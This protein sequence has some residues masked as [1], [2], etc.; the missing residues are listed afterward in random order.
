M[1]IHLRR[2]GVALVLTSA[3][4]AVSAPLAMADG[5]AVSAQLVAGKLQ[6]TG[7]ALNDTVT[8]RL[9]T[10]GTID[11]HA[12]T[13]RAPDF[14]FRR[15]EVSTI[16][17]DLG[18]G[19]DMVAMVET[20]GSFTDTIPTTISTGDG[21][22]EITG[23]RGDETLLAGPGPDV[24]DG[25]GGRDLILLG[26]GDDRS[27]WAPGDGTDVIEGQ[28]GSD[29]VQLLGSDTAADQVEISANGSR[30][31]ALVVGSP[32]LADLAGIDTLKVRTDGG[33][34]TI[35]VNDL[36][37]TGTTVVDIDLNRP[38]NIFT[39][40]DPDQVF[41]AGT[42]SGD[43]VT[44]TGASGQ[45]S[46]A[47]LAAEVRI[48]GALVTMD[49]V[50]V[51]GDS[52]D[53]RFTV[54]PAAG[55][56]L[57]TRIDGG[58]GDDTTITNGTASNDDVRVRPDH[59]WVRVSKG[60]GTYDATVEHTL[61]NGLDGK[62]W[63]ETAGNLDPLTD[64]VLDG[65]PGDD[66]VT[67]SEGA[68]TLLGGDGLDQVIGHQGDDILLLGAGPDHVF[69]SPGD[70]SDII[71][72]QSGTDFLNVR[73]SGE[74]DKVSISSLGSR[75]RLKPSAAEALD[76]DGME[77]LNVSPLGGADSVIVDELSGTAVWEVVV[78][79][80]ATIGGGV[81][82]GSVDQIQVQG[83]NGVDAIEVS[84]SSESVTVEGLNPATRV[85]RTDPSDRLL[86][87]TLAGADQVLTTGL[88]PGSIE[89]TVI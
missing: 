64:V 37:G 12:G 75:I 79:V 13:S 67:G 44:V 46:A 55:Q 2:A 15:T 45:F 51:D 39:D 43:A 62:D 11:V 26:S 5:P 58:G 27:R 89:L 10:S 83:T 54:D 60:I 74:S 17:V 71:E 56:V 35:N 32:D 33:A 59:G 31:R 19:N 80:E 57:G 28:T 78:N 50:L 47:G 4:L 20:N 72:G 70:G 7:S 87:D 16:A 3:L 6:I 14:R 21:A 65:G 38:G 69:W 86:I 36:S 25:R 18:N 85:R 23:G 73:G 81:A 82:D 22:D 77:H 52:G 49:Q 66:V 42:P 41:V 30:V 53:D 48:R 34:D 76:L 1:P 24:V 84:G 68:E 29:T 61:I 8:V 9:S 63:L 88:A 40:A